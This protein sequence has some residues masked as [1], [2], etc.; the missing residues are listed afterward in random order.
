[1]ILFWC[2][3]WLSGEKNGLFWTEEEGGH[4]VYLTAMALSVE[5]RV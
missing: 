5:Q 2:S 1:M 4:E 3:K